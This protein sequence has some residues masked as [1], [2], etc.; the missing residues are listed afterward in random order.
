MAGGAIGRDIGLSPIELCSAQEL[1]QASDLEDAA[2]NR[3]VSVP[4][5]EIVD[6]VESA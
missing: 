5:G 3:R 1:L 4:R 2:M 6:Y